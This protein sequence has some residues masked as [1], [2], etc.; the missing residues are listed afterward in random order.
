MKYSYLKSKSF[1][2]PSL[3][4]LI[5]A[6]IY[7]FIL[8]SGE[9]KYYSTQRMLTQWD[10]QHYLSIARD[11]YEKYPCQYSSENICGN[12]G[13]FPFYP[14]VGSLLS[15]LPISI[16]LIMIG[17]SWLSF[18]LALLLIYRFVLKLYSENI[19]LWT[20]IAML[21]FPSS[22]YFLT[23][24]PYAIY[25]LLTMLIFTFLFDRKYLFLI[26]CTAMLAVTY[27]SG[28]VIFLPLVYT[29][30]KERNSATLK[31]KIQLSTS[32][33]TIGLGLV[34]YCT[35]NYIVFGDFFLYN[36]FQAQSYYAH[37]ATFPLY[38]IYETLTS[39][40]IT[41]TISLTLIFIIALVILFY[42][43]SIDIRLQIFMF[44]IL[45]F[46]PSAGTTDCYYR[47][48]IVAFPLFLMIGKA[49]ESE[50]RKYLLPL[51][52]IVSILLIF[53]LYLPLYKSGNLM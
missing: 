51:Y 18:W 46:T 25:L 36:T 30:W 42:Q 43:K 21:I 41:H 50:K 22:F 47:H 39:L 14:L 49:I 10:G 3:L 28:I 26:P 4:F 48:I 33:I 44:G 24:F 31:E 34:S 45:L 12:I 15:F 20:I 53:F 23:V 38:T 17:L 27:P 35:Y 11:G 37:Q 16:N 29:L 32:I 8:Q 1:Y 52:C 9:H 5:F 40:P 13:W 6:I 19:A 2:I 7:M